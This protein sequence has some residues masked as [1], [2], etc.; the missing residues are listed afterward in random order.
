M[1]KKL[2]EILGVV[3]RS[4]KGKMNRDVDPRYLA[5]GDFLDALNNRST[6]TDGGSTGD[7]EN[8]LGNE[9]AFTL[10]FVNTSYQ[11]Y[12]IYLNSADNAL[13]TLKIYDVNSNLIATITWTPTIGDL[14]ATYTSAT[15]SITTALFG[16]G[17]HAVMG[18]LSGSGDSGYFTIFIDVAAG[19]AVNQQYNYIISGGSEPQPL[20]VQESIL[21]SGQ[22]RCIGSYDLEGDLYVWSTIQSKM[23]LPITITNV[24][25]A[26]GVIEITIA[27]TTIL[28]DL[29]LVEIRGVIG[30][31]ANGIWALQITSSTTFNLVASTF[32]GSYVSGGIA[33]INTVGVGEVGLARKNE[34]D[35][36]W[37]YYTL[38]RSNRFNFRT[39]KQIKTYCEKDAI[40]KSLYWT[41]DYNVPRVLYDRT[42]VYQD[43]CLLNFVDAVNSYSYDTLATES[44]LLLNNT[45]LV[46]KFTGQ[47]QTGG[48]ILSGN[49]RYAV[50]LVTESN[51]FTDWTLLSNPVPATIDSEQGSGWEFYGRNSGNHTPKINN[52]QVTGNVLGIFKYIELAA[53]NYL[54]VGYSGL[55]VRRDVIPSNDFSIQHNGNETGTDLD[56]GT[57]AGF[58]QTYTKA[59]NIDSLAGSLI[60]SNLETAPQVDLSDYF[61]NIEY[62]LGKKEISQSTG[63]ALNGSL[64]VGEYQLSDNVYEFSGYMLNERYRFGFMV[65]WKDGGMSSV[66]Y[67]NDIVFDLNTAS[68]KN[69]LSSFTDY[70]ICKAVYS[71]GTPVTAKSLSPFVRFAINPND[72]VNGYRLKD[73]VKKV[74]VMRCPVDKPQVLACG[75]AIPAI[76][77][78]VGGNSVNIGWGHPSFSSGQNVQYG[79]FPFVAGYKMGEII[80]PP[81]DIADNYAYPDNGGTSTQN[82][83]KRN[84]YGSFYFLDYLYGNIGIQRLAGDKILNFGQPTVD[85]STFKDGDYSDYLLEAYDA[86]LEFTTF[87]SLDIT[88][89]KIVYKGDEATI[90]SIT[91]SK[92]LWYEAAGSTAFDAANGFIMYFAS[93]TLDP[94]TSNSDAQPIYYCQYYRQIPNVDDQ[95]G[96][97]I[98]SVYMWTG[99]FLDCDTFNP[100]TD[101]LDVFG[102]DTVSQKCWFKNRYPT[103]LATVKTGFGQGIGF[104]CQN[105]INFQM[106]TYPQ[107]TFPSLPTNTA[108][109]RW[110]DSA[111]EDVL[112]NN[113]GYNISVT[114]LNVLQSLPAYNPDPEASNTDFP[115]RIA[116]SAN[117][118]P[119]TAQDN[120]RVFLPEN[121][122]D[123]DFKNGEIMHHAIANGELITWQVLNIMRQYF[124]PTGMLKTSDGSEIVL[125]DAAK[126]Q[127]RGT[128]ITT[129]GTKNGFS[130]ARGKTQGGNDVFYWMDTTNKGVFRLIL[131][132]DG[133]VNL[134][135]VHG[136][137][138]FF[139]ENMRFVDGI[140]TPADGVG[141][142]STW[143]ER[144]KEAIFTVRGYKQ[145]IPVYD[146]NPSLDNTYIV[147]F[148][149]LT[150]TFVNGENVTGNLGADGTISHVGINFIAVSSLTQLFVVTEVITGGTSGATADTLGTANSYSKDVVVSYSSTDYEGFPDFYISLIDFNGQNV[151]NAHYWRKISHSDPL[152]YNQYTIAFNE[153]TNG[154]D[155]FYSFKPKIYLPYKNTYLSPK[156]ISNEGETYEHGRGKYNTWYVTQVVDGFFTFVVNA[157]PDSIKRFLATRFRTLVVPKRVDIIS[158]EGQHT[159]MVDSDYVLREGNYDAAVENDIVTSSNGN[160]P[161]EQ[162]S[163]IV[164]D[165][166]TVK[167]TFEAQVLQKFFMMVMRIKIR[168]RSNNS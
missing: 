127:R 109:E 110:L 86:P 137:D 26:S 4:R 36:T 125:G 8:V 17:Y 80:I 16:L 106:R 157:L 130:I 12:R 140:D 7:R 91:Y 42:V 83:V 159:Y 39:K 41:D 5:N 114:G 29:G 122:K 113:K 115:T 133:T 82:F 118:I 143:N 79:E 68:H 20:E 1:A 81:P 10:P 48:N 98:D 52:F 101:V 96:H 93:G 32:S 13:R 92:R 35:Q 18:T 74:Y 11:I 146:N 129:Y 84:H 154:F 105:R 163:K 162:T 138:S 47:T 111:T 165:Y 77:N 116:Y 44:T 23:P 148:N 24:L 152:Y 34:N 135:L 134:G 14:N 168:P 104:Y 2:R 95:Y 121:F 56:T 167:V 119:G 156:P 142:C 31:P 88:E 132:G 136:M 128:T 69:F 85:F 15:G 117:K 21:E 100:S 76:S 145:G 22:L 38:I 54:N 37:S 63:S 161:K 153:V 57:L 75:I 49:W 50:R 147:Y 90:N 58:K 30:V 149:N 73:L 70:N 3:F 123:L 120:Y 65:E 155:T 166:C 61:A 45:D 72:I 19:V 103:N 124:D 46:F 107:A 27:D 150:G 141:I 71:S 112:S 108:I 144:N 62:Y 64:T 67:G 126:L 139:A 6:T 151:T 43:N 25:S 28:T 66:Y 131:N 99:A 160:N 33:T 55:I 60:L 53:I 59:K 87:T 89:G 78:H 94:I 51:T 9:L 40:K 102:G 158:S 97:K 164:G